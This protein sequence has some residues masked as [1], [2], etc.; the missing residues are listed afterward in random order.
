MDRLRK[1]KV[2]NLLAGIILLIL[3]AYVIKLV[4][5]LNKFKEACP[6]IY[7]KESVMAP[8]GQ[9]ISIDALADFEKAVETRIVEIVEGE[10]TTDASISE[11]GS[12]L[13]VGTAPVRYDVVVE[14]VGANHERVQER[15]TV[16]VYIE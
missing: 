8:I 2:T 9:T 16:N 12:R 15:V 14:A 10:K 1:S 3:V 7:P 6:A 11:D 4:I 5:D 13:H